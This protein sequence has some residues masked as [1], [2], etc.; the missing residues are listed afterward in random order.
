MNN[1]RNRTMWGISL[2][3]IGIATIINA[4]SSLL[5]IE[6]PDILVRVVGVIT[7]VALP[8]LV[9]SSVKILKNSKS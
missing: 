6:L 3:I 4:F 2:F 5:G 8:V 7:I 9:Y 1:K